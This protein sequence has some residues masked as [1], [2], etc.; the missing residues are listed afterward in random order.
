MPPTLRKWQQRSMRAPIANSEL[1]EIGGKQL[2][3]PGCPLSFLM[4]SPESESAF[5]PLHFQLECSPI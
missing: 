2:A 5:P 4:V 1:L 3:L